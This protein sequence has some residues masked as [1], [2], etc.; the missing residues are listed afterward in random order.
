MDGLQAA[1]VSSYFSYIYI[2]YTRSIAPL[3]RAGAAGSLL[4]IPSCRGRRLPVV[5][6][7]SCGLLEVA[8]PKG[9]PLLQSPDAGLEVPDLPALDEVSPLLKSDPHELPHS[10]LSLPSLHHSALV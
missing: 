8:G 1:R 3:P 9:P 4:G 10:S 2:S 5:H 6:R 7:N